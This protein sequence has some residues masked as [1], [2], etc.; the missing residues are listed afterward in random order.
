MG[1]WV[2]I[3]EGERLTQ[4][5]VLPVFTKRKR[6]NPTLTSNSRACCVSTQTGAG[7]GA[8]AAAS[9]P[10]MTDSFSEGL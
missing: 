8:K 10:R 7:S 6:R 1:I 9:V 4:V 5:C 3:F 2:L